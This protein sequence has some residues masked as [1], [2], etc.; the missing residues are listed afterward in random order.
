MS[1]IEQSFD[2]SGLCPVVMF[3][4]VYFSFHIVLLRVLL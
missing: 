3:L 1:L 4:G 2:M